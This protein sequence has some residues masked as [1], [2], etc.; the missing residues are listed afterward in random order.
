[1]AASNTVDEDDSIAGSVSA[2]DA[3]FGETAN[4][5]FALVGAAPTGLVFNPDGTYTFDAGSYDSLVGGDTL[6]LTIPFTTTDENSATSTS[7]DLT[8]TIN[9]TNDTPV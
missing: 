6:E 1:N 3:D 7:A 8:I 5:T 9:G 2:T 4:L